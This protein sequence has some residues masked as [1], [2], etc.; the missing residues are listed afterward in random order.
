MVSSTGTSIQNYFDWAN[1]ELTK[2]E[3]GEVSLKFK[4]C[5]GQVVG[6]EKMSIDSDRFELKSKSIK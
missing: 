3:Y 2:K 1:K 5:N 4:V 6:V